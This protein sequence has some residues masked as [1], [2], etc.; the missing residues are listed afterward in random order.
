MPDGRMGVLDFGAVA[1]LP[2]GLPP[3]MGHLLR[4]AT[5]GD[6]DAVSVGDYHLPGI[7][8]LALAGEE[9]G[10]D[11]RMLELAQM[12]GEVT[13]GTL[14]SAHDIL[15]SAHLSSVGQKK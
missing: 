13:E 5:L 10:T 9:G 14:R 4:I 12:L 3:S 7:V 6:A 8:C 2:E 15:Q 11:E 1:R